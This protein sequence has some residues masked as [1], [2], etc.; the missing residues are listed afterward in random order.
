MRPRTSKFNP[1]RRICTTEEF[2]SHQATFAGRVE[3][4]RYRGNPEHKRHPGD[5]NLTPQSAPRPGKT[6]CDR[7]EIFSSAQAL[8]LLHAGF[9]RGL[10]SLQERNG[11][12]QNVWAVTDRGEP[13][14]A[15]LEGDGIYHGYPM[16]E[17]DPFRE[18]V[19]E[20]WNLG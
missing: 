9:L 16:P 10:L 17:A 2:L 14:E 6:L 8:A 13:L 5:Y 20:R 12:P 1:K 19:L 4:I 7:V 11:W 3:N 15:Q 18:T